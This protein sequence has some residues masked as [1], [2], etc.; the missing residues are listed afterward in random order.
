M[1]VEQVVEQVDQVDKVE[2][3]STRCSTTSHLIGVTCVVVLVRRVARLSCPVACHLSGRSPVRLSAG[4]VLNE[5]PPRACVC[6]TNRGTSIMNIQAPKF[7]GRRKYD[8][9][10]RKGQTKPESETMNSTVV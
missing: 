8:Q 9:Q 2:V 1:V 3:V 4:G 10:E 5:L 7:I 6:G